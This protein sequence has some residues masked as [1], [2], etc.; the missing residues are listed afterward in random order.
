MSGNNTTEKTPTRDEIRA[1]IFGAKPESRTIDFFGNKIELRQPT[2]ADAMRM[3]RIE[4]EEAMTQMLVSYA[5]VPKTQ[6]HIFE[7]ADAEAIMGIP[8]GPDMQRF[9]ETFNDLVGV[10]TEGL[11]K[12]VKD[13]V[14]SSEGGTA[15][16]DGDDD[17]GGAA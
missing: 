17:S 2:I 9:T 16:P 12:R 11:D 7:E 8:F 10:K 5:F 4:Q 14:K 13:A 1:A 6:D 15:T 3:Q